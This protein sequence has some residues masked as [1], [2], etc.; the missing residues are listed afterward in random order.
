ML[1]PICAV[2]GGE[3]S[4]IFDLSKFLAQL[5]IIKNKHIKVI[6]NFKDHFWCGQRESNSHGKFPLGPQPSLS[7]SFS[8]AAYAAD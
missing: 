7:T 1:S 2:G 6:S 8:M 4:K 5:H 3:T